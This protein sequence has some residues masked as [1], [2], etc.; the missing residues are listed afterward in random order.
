M[1][2]TILSVALLAAAH[3]APVQTSSIK[4]LT[5][6]AQLNA[7]TVTDDVKRGVS[8]PNTS[9]L[10]KDASVYTGGAITNKRGSSGISGV[11]V[12]ATTDLTDTSD[13][14][15]DLN[16][17][18]ITKL[19]QGVKRGSSGVSGI[20]TSN[21]GGVNLGSTVSSVEKEVGALS[22]R[23]AQALTS[24]SSL[25]KVLAQVSAILDGDLPDAQKVE[26][27][28]DELTGVLD[29]KRSA[30]SPAG[31]LQLVESTLTDLENKL[32]VPGDVKSTLASILA[33]VQ[34]LLAEV[35]ATLGLSDLDEE[36]S[37]TLKQV[38]Q[39][40][41]EIEGDIGLDISLNTILAKVETAV[42]KLLNEIKGAAKRD[43]TDGL[44]AEVESLLR[45]ILKE[46][47]VSGS[48]LDLSTVTSLLKQVDNLLAQLESE[49]LNVDVTV[50]TLLTT[51]ETEL[52]SLEA[53]LGLGINVDTLLSS[54]LSEVKKLLAQ[55]EKD[56]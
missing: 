31:V 56:L 34:S 53:D 5:N 3:A 25:D 36:L 33:T 35:E 7:G 4:E 21:V 43:A 29:V 23:D 15:K 44:L 39:T 52:T 20:D 27:I 16:L 28:L 9:V 38:E 49:V 18:S 32:G 1:R 37:V 30:L 2:Y 45:S 48:E 10:T 51:I 22:A 54:L 47:G 42:T 41:T 24:A 12:P 17:N 55:I 50:I 11:D 26:Q 8:I 6:E 46:L 40:L 19:T 14:T 13:L